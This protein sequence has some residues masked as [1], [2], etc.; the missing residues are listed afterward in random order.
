[1][2]RTYAADVYTIVNGGFGGRLRDEPATAMTGWLDYPTDVLDLEPGDAVRRRFTISV[3]QAAVP[4]EYIT[5]VVLENEVPVPGSG[6]VAL[7]QV[8]RQAVAVVVTIPGPRRPALTIGAARHEVA[9]GV[10]IVS[11]AV[12]NPGNVRLKPLVGF[13]LF[14]SAG[15][16]VSATQFRM[17][18]FYS[19]TTSSIE[20]PLGSILQPGAYTIALGLDDA[21]NDVHVAESAIPLVVVAAA[22][23][24]PAGGDVSE[25]PGVDQA[26]PPA[27]PNGLPL[28][29]AGLLLVAVVGVALGAR[30]VRR[31]RRA[32]S[33]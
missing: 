31:N 16:L 26:S 21:A 3:P 9:A 24:A 6:P 4:G 12:A 7:G 18:T 15:H 20:V 19:W 13:R 30:R 5:S 25:L 14:D 32:A 23:G 27:G 17:D 10:S 29:M 11:V 28:A 8:T 1:V 22:V 33:A 2:A